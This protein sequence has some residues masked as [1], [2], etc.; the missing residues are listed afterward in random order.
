MDSK[1]LDSWNSYDE[2]MD[3]DERQGRLYSSKRILRGFVKFVQ[4]STQPHIIRCKSVLNSKLSSKLSRER[5]YCRVVVM[6]NL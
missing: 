1:D 4:T 3:D 6:M 2:I 5:W